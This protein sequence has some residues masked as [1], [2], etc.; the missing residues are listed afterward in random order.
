MSPLAST[1]HSESLSGRYLNET[2][3][4]ESEEENEERE[5]GVQLS[6]G[7]GDYIKHRDDFLCQRESSYSVVAR[8]KVNL[9]LKC[10]LRSD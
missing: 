10:V 8:G 4:G 6:R 2:T 9:R 1:R 3:R 5:S 7:A